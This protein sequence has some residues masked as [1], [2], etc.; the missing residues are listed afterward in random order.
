MQTEPPLFICIR[1]VPG[2]DR[3]FLSSTNPRDWYRGVHL[4]PSSQRRPPFLLP[5]YYGRYLHVFEI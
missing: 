1:A 3:Q 5:K 4:S 2:M